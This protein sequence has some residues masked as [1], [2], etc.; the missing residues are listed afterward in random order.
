MFVLL[1]ASL[2]FATYFC[3]PKGFARRFCIANS[4]TDFYRHTTR[5]RVESPPSTIKRNIHHGLPLPLQHL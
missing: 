4:Q 1:F 2:T 3:T 5:Y